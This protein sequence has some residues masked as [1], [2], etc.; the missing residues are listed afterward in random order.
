[1]PPS[2]LGTQR[3]FPRQRPMCRRT[4]ATIRRHSTPPPKSTRWLLYVFL[5]AF[6]SFSRLLDERPV[7]LCSLE[8]AALLSSSSTGEIL[9]SSSVNSHL[10]GFHSSCVPFFLEQRRPSHPNFLLSVSVLCSR[11]LPGIV[12]LPATQFHI[13]FSPCIFIFVK[14]RT[15]STALWS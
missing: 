6:S 14:E 7:Q 8:V 9:S 10:L 4:P 13:A 11:S 2:Q 15:D 5:G 1:M 3:D 12:W